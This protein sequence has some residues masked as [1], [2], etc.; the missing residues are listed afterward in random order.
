MRKATIAEWILSLTVAPERA[1]TTVGDLL[2]AGSDRGPL[3]FWSSIL[4]TAFFHA[5][6]DFFASPALMLW[7]AF[8][9]WVTAVVANVVLSNLVI[10]GILVGIPGWRFVKP[11]PSG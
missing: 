1:A 11:T 3:W 6:D 4:R 2:E 5:M 7:L 10:N 9:G 8:G